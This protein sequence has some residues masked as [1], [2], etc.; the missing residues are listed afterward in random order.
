MTWSPFG[1]RS[2]IES[3]YSSSKQRTKAFFNNI[4]S[5]P[6]DRSERFKRSTLCWELFI[7]IHATLHH[8]RR[9]A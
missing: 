8:L 2:L 7:A 5:N 9:W 6:L 1:D 3:V 4:T